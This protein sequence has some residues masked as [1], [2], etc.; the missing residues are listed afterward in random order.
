ML[1]RL[2]F[3]RRL[4]FSMDGELGRG[5]FLIVA[6]PVWLSQHLFA[7][8]CIQLSSA[9]I[10]RDTNEQV[11]FAVNPLRA[12]FPL[13]DQIVVTVGIVSMVLV[14]WSLTALSF[15]R[16]RSAGFS[17]GLGV[18]MMV[19]FAQ[20]LAL[21]MFATA[22]LKSSITVV[23]E[24]PFP[25]ESNMRAAV[26]GAAIG[27]LVCVAAVVFSTLVFH[28]YGYG[29]FLATPC[30]VGIVA[31]YIATPKRSE[32]DGYPGRVAVSA[33]VLGGCMIFGV[34]AEGLICLLMAAPLAIPVCLVG[35]AIGYQ[36]AKFQR[37]RTTL[38][39]VAVLPL[40]IMLEAAF[41]TDATF[42]SVRSVEIAAQPDAVWR[43]ITHM[44]EIHTPP[45]APFGWGLAY[46][47]AGEIN[48]EGVGAVRKGVFSTGVAYERVTVWD[49]GH[50]LTFKVLSDPPALR[51]LSPYDN[52]SAPHL[53]GYFTTAYAKFTL[54]P[55]PGGRTRLSLETQHTLRLEP[56]VYWTPLARLAIEENKRRVLQHFAEQAEAMGGVPPP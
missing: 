15:R 55:L 27:M 28:S 19:P 53:A 24:E 5:A 43:S 29:V 11:L 26:L 39:A 8:I 37:R 22:P 18:V 20:P 49:P 38:S 52:V 1:T 17:P 36:A 12:L 47:I 3:V 14:A 44:G 45:A 9:S 25:N 23:E 6:L 56:A 4:L 35:A 21:L 54:E 13:K 46:P 16:A 2:K 32:D 42:V 30:V 10:L 41:P 31:G 51:E 33:L 40:L 7:A 48:G 50:E 34:A